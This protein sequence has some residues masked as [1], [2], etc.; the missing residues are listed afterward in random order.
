MR[1]R[2]SVA[3]VTGAASGIGRGAAKMLALA[4]A[5]I[6]LA[7]VNQ[8][9]MEEARAEIS[10][11][12]G[13]QVSA[14]RCDVSRDDDV[15]NL[16][17]FVLNR[18]DHVDILMNNAGVVLRGALEEIGTA[19]WEWQFGINVFG[20]WRGIRAFLPHMLERGRGHIVNTASACGLFAPT[21]EGAPY[22]ASKFAVVGMTESLALYARPRGIGV[23]LLCPGSVDTN[24][25]ETGR[26]IA[27]TPE[28]AVAET[29]AAATVQGGG[30]MSPD[31]VGRLVVQAVEEER[32]FVLAD[33]LHQGLVERRAQDMNAYLALRLAGQPVY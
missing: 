22:V 18:C 30:V 32:Y 20:V 23:S 14:V 4:G 17:H 15:A 33:P 28:R 31:H 24:L 19:D 21:G 8:T 1:I 27:M 7:D 3:V 9:R 16:A 26:T 6:V 13:R 10:R 11:L 12:S 5:D 25:S 29:A 2:D